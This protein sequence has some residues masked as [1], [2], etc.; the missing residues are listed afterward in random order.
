LEGS[1]IT[2]TGA[3]DASGSEAYNKALSL[4]RIAAVKDALVREGVPATAFA[5]N[6][7]R[8]QDLLVQTSNG[9]RSAE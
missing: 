8:E 3:S 6:S 9:A 2:A 4:H 1:R 7:H 5:A